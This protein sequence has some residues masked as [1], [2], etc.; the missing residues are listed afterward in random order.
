[1]IDKNKLIDKKQYGDLV[2]VAKMLKVTEGNA[3][4]LINR[5]GAKRHPEAIAALS[6]IIESRER[7]INK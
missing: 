7:L 4:Q 1:M 5:E 6:E 2:I 3:R